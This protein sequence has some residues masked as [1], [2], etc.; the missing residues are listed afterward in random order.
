[1]PGTIESHASPRAPD[2]RSREIRAYL[3]RLLTT[4]HFAA[5]SRRGQLLQ[6]LVNQTLAGEA[7][8]VT[9]Y[10]IGL[11]VF[12]KPSSFDPRIE[13]VVRTEFSRLRQRLKDYYADEGLRDPIAI[14]FPPRTYAATF[15]FRDIA[16]IGTPQLVPGKTPAA[17]SSARLLVLIAVP[18]LL[19]IA[20]TAFMLWKQHLPPAALKQP[21]NAIVVLPFANY[22]PDHQDE[23]I[24]D[25]MTEEL[26]NDLA[27]W[28]DLRV[29]ARTSAFAFKGKGEDVRTIGQ[30]LNVD[31]VLEGSFTRQGD[32]VR[33]TAQLNRT[34]DGYHLWSHSYETQSNDL[35]SVQQQVANSISSAIGQIRGGSPP[36]IRASTTDPEAH[37]LYLQ[38]RFQ[39]NLRTPDS[40]NKAIDLFRAAVAKD[41]SFARAYVGISEAEIAAVSLTTT[42]NQQS[43]PSARQAAQKAIELD[44]SLGEAYGLLAYIDYVWDWNWT[45]ADAEFRRAVDLGASPIA[46]AHY[47]W[48]L[49]TRGRFAEAHD[50]LVLAAEQDP[51][52]VVPPFDEFFAYNFE[53]NVPGQKQ[54]LQRMLQIRPDFLGAHA[55]SVVMSVEQR[56]CATA[57]T[58][59]DYL[60]KTYPTVPATHATLAFAAACANNKAETQRQIK[61]MTAL[62]APAYQL[63]IAYALLHDKDNAIAQLSKSADAHEGQILY[64]KYDPFFDSIRS[65]PR[66]VALESRVGLN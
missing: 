58:E 60:A 62:N 5:A 41:P 11:D 8:K 35:L 45:G 56:D 30:Q 3:A 16:S 20:V 15:D 32:H 26:T 36:A 59:A 22:S 21:I 19:A 65:D 1:M 25:G 2:S 10:A 14:D 53:R 27:Q 28:R 66:Y 18:T 47:G 38:G 33:I 63:A 64:L 42:T 29:V 49:A 51:L 17:S 40:L 57:R 43:I 55:L 39:F 52:S 6:Y 24:A 37:D 23:Y 7:D 31:A 44:P 46:R 12:Q 13:S 61:Q 50:Q 48:S 4:P 54:A 34:A 9:E